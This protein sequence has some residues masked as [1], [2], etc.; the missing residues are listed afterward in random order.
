MRE[1][2]LVVAVGSAFGWAVALALGRYLQPKLIGVPVGDPL[3]YAGVPAVLL[4]VAAF[5]CWLPARRAAKV[6]PIVA[7]RTE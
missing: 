2:L 3:I 1:G 5:A 7:L 6:D 4:A